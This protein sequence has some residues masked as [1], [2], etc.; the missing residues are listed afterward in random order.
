MQ[1][2]GIRIVITGSTGL[3]GSHV[4]EFLE[5][6]DFEVYCP[7][8]N[9]IFDVVKKIK[10]SHIINCIGAGMDHRKNQSEDS[11]WLANYTIPKQIVELACAL[12]SRFISIG[13]LLEK[14]EGFNSPYILSKR[15]FSEFLLS[16]TGLKL[17]FALLLTPIV[18]G[19][20]PEHA[21][22]S[23]I[24]QSSQS[25]KPVKL[26]SPSAIRDFVHVSD[27]SLAIRQIIKKVNM[28]HRVFEVGSG[29]G[30]V[31]S[32][33][34]EISLKGIANPAW[35]HVNNTRTNTFEVVADLTNIQSTLNFKVECELEE[36]IKLEI[37]RL[38]AEFR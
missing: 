26:E 2:A 14:I 34:C 10:P 16:S 37:K 24:L 28:D 23:E 21:L 29:K 18:F 30:Y 7:A 12:D 5:S 31:L 4:K 9:E 19:V 35:E 15:A 25:R 8:R 17:D 36:W 32:S 1:S 22:L 38:E 13:S 6:E 3:I 33:L 11:I 20:K 27:L